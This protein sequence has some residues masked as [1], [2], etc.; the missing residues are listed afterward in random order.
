MV[1]KRYPNLK[2]ERLPYFLGQKPILKDAEKRQWQK[3]AKIQSWLNPKSI[4]TL[5]KNKDSHL[6]SISYL[7][8]PLI[9]Q[10]EDSFPSIFDM[11]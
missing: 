9:F 2:A 7:Y 10:V 6:M 4:E 5:E 8:H 1:K 11:V 3:K